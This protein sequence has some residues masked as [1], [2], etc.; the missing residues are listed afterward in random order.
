[1]TFRVGD[2]DSKVIVQSQ[3]VSRRTRNRDY[4]IKQL[5]KQIMEILAQRSQMNYKS[6]VNSD[7]QYCLEYIT[8][9]DFK[10]AVRLSGQEGCSPLAMSA[11]D[12]GWGQL[13]MSVNHN[14]QEIIPND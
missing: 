4:L 12:K 10:Y 2:L 8:E 3:E 7:L 13:H 1:M 6:H 5:I 9:K 11:M 14:I